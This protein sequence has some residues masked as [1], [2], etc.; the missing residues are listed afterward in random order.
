MLLSEQEILRRQKR[1]ELVS[2]G[3]EPYPA[4]SFE[5]NTTIRDILMHWKHNKFDFKDVSV[6][7]V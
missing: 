7:G 2:L 6:P 4:E 3:I 1:D 5:T